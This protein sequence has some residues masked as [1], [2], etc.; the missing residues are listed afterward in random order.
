MSMTRRPALL[1]MAGLWAVGPAG[2]E[3]AA[4]VQPPEILFGQ[5]TCDLCG[6]IISDDRFA[7]GLAVQA[8]GRSETRAFDDIGCLLA[9]EREHADETVAARYVHDFGTRSWRDAETAAYLHSGRLHSPMAF[10]LAALA[11]EAEAQALSEEY[12]GDVLDF[13]AV[14]ERFESGRLTIFPNE[15]T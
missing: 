7:A 9:Y 12:P 8:G 13:P 6:M 14:R 15:D 5:D 10:G 11:T 2:C 3:D 4:S 1:L